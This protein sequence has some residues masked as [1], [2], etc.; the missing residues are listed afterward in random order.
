M[1]E[2]CIALNFSGISALEFSL[3]NLHAYISKST[4]SNTVCNPFQ[5]FMQ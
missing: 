3:A 5:S 1:K 2:F 4:L